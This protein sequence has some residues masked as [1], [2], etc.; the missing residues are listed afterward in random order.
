MR[1]LCVYCAEISWQCALVRRFCAG[2]HDT[3]SGLRLH[4]VNMI[5][6]NFMHALACPVLRRTRRG[7]LVGVVVPRALPVRPERQAGRA[8]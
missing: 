6:R 4:P 1:L 8:A 7:G 5:L 2:I 3:E